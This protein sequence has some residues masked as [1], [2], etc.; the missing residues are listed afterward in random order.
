MI[1]CK[2]DIELTN[3][4]RGFVEFRT[5][6]EHVVHA[7][8]VFRLKLTGEGVSASGT[9]ALAHPN[10]GI[11]SLSSSSLVDIFSLLQNR[12]LLSRFSPHAI[13]SGMLIEF[14]VLRTGYGVRSTE[15]R[16]VPYRSHTRYPCTD[17]K[18]KGELI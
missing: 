5:P 16:I 4:H 3:Q 8:D 1:W 13:P 9:S 7:R 2:L 14:G 11:T 12:V 17:T 18:W 15:F 10:T 6:G